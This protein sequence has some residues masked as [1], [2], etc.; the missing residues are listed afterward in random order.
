MSLVVLDMLVDL[1]G[2]FL[3]AARRHG[4]RLDHKRLGHLPAL[5]VWHGNY[6]AVIDGGVREKM[7]FQLG[8]G[9]LVALRYVS[10]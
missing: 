4:R 10:F 9:D 3:I 7:G 5:V 1:G 6:G 2:H 8:G